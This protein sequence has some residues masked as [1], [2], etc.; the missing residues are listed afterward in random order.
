MI[1]KG[2]ARGLGITDEVTSPTFTIISGYEGRLRLHHVDAWRLTGAEDFH[3]IGGEDLLSDPGA[4]C[5]IE[6]SERLQDALPPDAE[7]IELLVEA[8]GYRRALVTGPR[9]EAMAQ[10]F[11]AGQGGK[12]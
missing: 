7:V 11:L 5:L 1:A 8:N 6:W 3:E 2:L 9:L 10:G 4:I 12:P